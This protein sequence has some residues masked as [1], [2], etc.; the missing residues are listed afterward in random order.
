[1]TIRKILSALLLSLAAMAPAAHAEVVIAAH[2]GQTGSK[3]PENTLAA[4]RDAIDR[5]VAIIEVDLRQTRDGHIVILHDATLDR[6]TNGT[7]PVTALTLAQVKALDAGKG[8]RVP[9]FDE[10]LALIAPSDT[11]LLLDL[12]S[13]ADLPPERVLGAARAQKAEDHLIIGARSASDAH[14]YRTLSPTIPILGFM[15]SPGDIAAYAKAGANAVRLWPRWI[16]HDDTA[17]AL[18]A[19]VHGAGMKLWVTADAPSN[20]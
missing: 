17:R 5:K 16:L 12:K 9:T 4:F 13:T 20:P 3:L 18:I 10:V 19:Q 14:A 11:K 1:M 6:T 8:E 7:G 15:P 2:R